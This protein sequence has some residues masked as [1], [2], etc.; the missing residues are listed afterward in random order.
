[1]IHSKSSFRSST[2]LTAG[3]LPI[4]SSTPHKAPQDTQVGFA[5]VGDRSHHLVGVQLHLTLVTPNFKL[6]GVKGCSC[7]ELIR[8]CTWPGL[9][10]ETPCN[11]QPAL[12]CCGA[13]SNGMCITTP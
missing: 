2:V 4:K 1:M 12:F 13:N 10:K 5:L 3:M 11:L 8:G 6:N 7:L 9:L